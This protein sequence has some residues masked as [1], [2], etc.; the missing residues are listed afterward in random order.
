MRMREWTEYYMNP[1]KKKIL[2]VIS[3]EFSNTRYSCDR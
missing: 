3:L 1:V 2:N